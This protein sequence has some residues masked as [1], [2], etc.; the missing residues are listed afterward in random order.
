MWWGYLTCSFSAH[1][2]IIRNVFSRDFIF[3]SSGWG[4]SKMLMSSSI[5]KLLDIH[6]S[7]HYTSFNACVRYFVLNFEVYLW[8][9]TQN[10]KHIYWKIWFLYNIENI[11]A[12]RFRSPYVFLKLRPEYKMGLFGTK[13][14]HAPMITYFYYMATLATN[15]SKI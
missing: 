14:S 11:K 7:I 4:I 9:S 2:A 15:F 12:D 10:I 6:F 5:W 8:N 13:P 3:S 1:K